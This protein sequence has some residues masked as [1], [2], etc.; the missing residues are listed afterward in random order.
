MAGLK[1]D[2][3]PWVGLVAI[4][5]VNGSLL[6]SVPVSVISLGVFPVT[7]TLCALAVGAWFSTVIETV[8]GALSV[9]TVVNSKCK[10]CQVQ[11][12]SQ[13]EYRLPRLWLG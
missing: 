9:S 4:E 2:K 3:V 5:N 6:G 10:A 8:A 7:V 11:H 12:S 13:P 1:P